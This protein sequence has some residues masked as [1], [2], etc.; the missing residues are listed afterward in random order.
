MTA[1]ETVVIPNVNSEGFYLKPYM[2][3]ILIK[4]D[5]APTQTE[6]GIILPQQAVK[7]TSEGLVVDV[8]DGFWSE[9]ANGLMGMGIFPGD[10]VMYDERMQL[11]IARGTRDYILISYKGILGITNPAGR[12]AYYAAQKEANDK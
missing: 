11:K 10:R 4:P 9:Q 5:D 6:S 7:N 2:G 3:T 12:V 8:G 1:S